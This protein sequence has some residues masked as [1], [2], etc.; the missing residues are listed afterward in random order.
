MKK[1][2]SILSIAAILFF[3]ANT[4]MAEKSGPGTPP[5]EPQPG[6]TPIGGGAPIGSGSMILFTLAAAYGVR[7]LYNSKKEDL[8]E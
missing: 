6:D 8:E 1:N 2:L 4:A 5:T 3:S 7:K